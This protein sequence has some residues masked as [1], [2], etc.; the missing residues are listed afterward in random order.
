MIERDEQAWLAWRRQGVTATDVADA[1]AGTYGGMYG[2]VARKLSLTP[3]TEQTPAMARGHRWQFKIADAIHALTGLHVVGE[4][5]QC[6]A[7]HNDKW[8]ATVDGFLSTYEVTTDMADLVGV[9]EVKTTG[10]GV[11]PDRDRWLHQV[12][13][14]LLVTGMNRGLIAHAVIDDSTDEFVSLRVTEVTADPMHQELLQELAG[15][16]LRHTEAGTLPDPDDGSALDVVKAVWADTDPTALP[17]DLTDL[18][19]EIARLADLSAAIKLAQSEKDSIEAL[20]RHRIGAGI[21]GST[22]QFRVTISKPAMVLSADAEARLIEEHPELTKRVLDRD[23][24]KKEAKDLYESLRQPSGARRMTV[25][26]IEG[27]N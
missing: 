11:R 9:L 14:Q 23:R 4:E 7:Q 2:V 15:E 12:Q 25:K 6:E 13:W 10:V 20:L 24:A 8:R 1:A 21:V 19:D 17:V 27:N 5:Q 22:E 3:V 26:A 18:A 16:I